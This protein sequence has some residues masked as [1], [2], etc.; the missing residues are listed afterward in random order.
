[1]ASAA[2]LSLSGK[3]HLS[4]RVLPAH[5]VIVNDHGVIIEIISNTAQDTVPL[6]YK[7]KLAKSTQTILSDDIIKQYQKLLPP[8]T[9]HPGVLYKKNV[10]QQTVPRQIGAASR[11]QSLPSGPAPSFGQKPAGFNELLK[12]AFPQLSGLSPGSLGPSPL[13]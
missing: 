12:L 6:V 2:T 8:G 4:G 9:S 10:S 1:M 5:Y 13:S 11:H 3:V 7:N